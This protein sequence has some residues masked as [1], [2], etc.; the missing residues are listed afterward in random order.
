M[1]AGWCLARDAVC[2]WYVNTADPF[3]QSLCRFR[4]PARLPR[5]VA[6]QRTAQPSAQR[7][8]SWALGVR[9]WAAVTGGPALPASLAADIATS[10]PSHTATA[11][12]VQRARPLHPLHLWQVWPLHLP[13]SRSR[14]GAWSRRGRPTTR[15]AQVTAS[16]RLASRE[17]ASPRGRGH[18]RLSSSPRDRRTSSHGQKEANILHRAATLEGD[19]PKARTQAH[20]LV[21]R[22]YAPPLCRHH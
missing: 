21:P 16:P 1:C 20:L 10:P 3:P 22:H 7:S 14:V 4:A 6:F 8:G 13:S 19:L 15:A 9:L 11:R 18:L 12:V 2:R 17:A 5:H